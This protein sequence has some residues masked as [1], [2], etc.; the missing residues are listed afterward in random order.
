[1]RRTV[2]VLAAALLAACFLG[3]I[4][5]VLSTSFKPDTEILRLP[6]RWLPV[7]FTVEHYAAVLSDPAVHRYI[8]NSLLVALATALTATLL[9]SLAAYGLARFRFRGRTL[10]LGLLLLVHLLPNLISM[11]ALYRMVASLG[12][13]D[14]LVGLALVKGAG[15]SL[16]VWLLKGYFTSL[17]PQYEEMAR[18]DGCGPFTVFRRVV[19]PLRFRGILVAG[20]F[21][22][23]QSWKSFFLPLLLITRKDRMTLPLGIFQYA[24]EHGF[25]IG[26]VCALSVLSMIPIL[27]L[28]LTL[29][30]LGWESLRSGA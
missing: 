1:M 17:P 3:P 25:E 15:L 12:L 5:W 22:F 2:N 30:R 23:A 10:L 13:L 14:S 28:L 7:P 19:L 20:L 21:F 9:G 6:V 4:A 27:L 11:T 8:L 26:R 16:V 18:V 24:G 29:N